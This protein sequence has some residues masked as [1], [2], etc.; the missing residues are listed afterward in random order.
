[1]V[2]QLKPSIELLYQYFDS[3]RR[4]YAVTR[5]YAVVAE[6]GWMRDQ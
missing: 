5:S 3:A 2:V 6:A 4:Y 1:M